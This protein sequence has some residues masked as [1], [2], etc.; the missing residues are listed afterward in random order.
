[1]QSY[2]YNLINN[3]DKE[4]FMRSLIKFFGG[5]INLFAEQSELLGYYIYL[6][7]MPVIHLGRFYAPHIC[8]AATTWAIEFSDK[9]LDT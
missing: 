8:I 7:H 6:C 2:N 4:Y 5:C 1:M 3:T 9:R